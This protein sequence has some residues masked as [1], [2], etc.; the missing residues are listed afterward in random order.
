MTSLY[1]LLLVAILMMSL[2][3]NAHASAN[4]D[5]KVPFHL[6][7]GLTIIQAEI[8]GIQG[9]FLLDTGS[10][11]IFI[12]GDLEEAHQH[13]IVSLGGISTISNT[14]L[15]EL[16]VGSFRQYKLDAQ[17]ISL[18]PIEEHLGIDLKGIIGGHI[19]RPRVM[20]FDFVA[21]QITLSDKLSKSEKTGFTNKIN[22]Q[23]I[24]DI[25]VVK[26]KIENKWYQFALDSG[27][28]IHFMDAKLLS[29]LSNVT[30]TSENS[31]LKCLANTN[32]SIQKKTI[33]SLS[34]GSITFENQ[35]CIPYSFETVNASTPFTLDGIL[36]L[37]Q[38][39]Q[40][41]III[42]YTRSKLYF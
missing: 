23:L 24:N 35:T 41:T 25:P 11:G 8:D 1:K 22:I 12:D 39:M 40:E 36:S 10:D 6:I 19:F 38:L 21:S 3:I 34:L 9:N 31:T 17:I 13:N 15:E 2:L 37:S 18:S 32:T 33:N 28:S 20:T 42:D 30:N 4:S 14:V 26:V 5:V 7:N 27:S 29:K 16:K